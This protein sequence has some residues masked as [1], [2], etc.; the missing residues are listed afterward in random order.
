MAPKSRHRGTERTVDLDHGKA[1]LCSDIHQRA[2]VKKI[3]DKMRVC[4]CGGVISQSLLT[5][6]RVAWRCTECGRYEIFNDKEA[7]CLKAGLIVSGQHGLSH[8][9]KAQRQLV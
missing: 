4:R 3:G 7:Q 5:K 1:V 8:S 6:N 2:D 9:E